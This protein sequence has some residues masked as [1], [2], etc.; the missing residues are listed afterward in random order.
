MK[1]K[2]SF[3]LK[4]FNFFYFRRDEIVCWRGGMW[5]WKWNLV[6]E[7]EKYGIVFLFMNLI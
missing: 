5:R 3:W 6:N 2:N 7:K 1:K 4:G